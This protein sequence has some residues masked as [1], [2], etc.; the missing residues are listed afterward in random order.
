MLYYLMDV[1]LDGPEYNYDDDAAM[2]EVSVMRLWRCSPA[3]HP[4]TYTHPFTHK[5]MGGV[6]TLIPIMFLIDYLIRTPSY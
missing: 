4:P 6:H 1:V 2:E 5:I 3:H